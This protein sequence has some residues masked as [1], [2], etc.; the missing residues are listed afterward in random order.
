MQPALQYRVNYLIIIY[1]VM[2]EGFIY[3]SQM[4]KF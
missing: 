4:E 3:N 2:Y 1:Y